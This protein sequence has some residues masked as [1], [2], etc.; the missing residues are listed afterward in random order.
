M[1]HPQ[2]IKGILFDN[3]GTLV[4]TLDLILSSFHFSLD[5][6]LNQHFPDEVLLQ[7]VGQPLETQ[8]WDFTEDPETHKELCRVY[9]EHNASI[10]DD[11][12]KP[13]DS[14]D[15]VLQVLADRGF[16]LGVVTSKRHAL[17]EHG[18]EILDLM[19]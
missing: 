9:R 15:E 12:I 18:L 13:F 5:K 6:V 16:E 14:I 10:H 11:G 8:M 4:D 19:K 7:K 2:K 1:S 17:A 3:D